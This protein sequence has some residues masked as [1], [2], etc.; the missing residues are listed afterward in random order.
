MTTPNTTTTKTATMHAD[1]CLP[2]APLMALQQAHA[3]I[4]VRE[5]QARLVGAGSTALR[6]SAMASSACSISRALA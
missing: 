4:A 6:S 3:W 5:P 2:T 1:P